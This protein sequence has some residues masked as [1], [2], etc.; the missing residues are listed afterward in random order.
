[1]P[2]PFR[3]LL[4]RQQHSFWIA[5]PRTDLWQPCDRFGHGGGGDPFQQTRV[6]ADS[7][8]PRRN[9]HGSADFVP[10]HMLQRILS[11]F[12]IHLFDK[13]LLGGVRMLEER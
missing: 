5:D 2:S 8:S 3:A 6:F 11:Q 12:R 10:A 4:R 9:Q 7:Y 13:P 1:V